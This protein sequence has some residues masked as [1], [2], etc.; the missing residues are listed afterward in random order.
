[1]KWK[2]KDIVKKI[3]WY[4]VFA[5]FPVKTEDGYKVWLEKVE[6][7]W[8]VHMTGGSYVYKLE[9]D[10][11]RFNISDMKVTKDDE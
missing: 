8:K 4:T 3:E 1:M 9:S 2:A 6:K 5:W 10:A 7:R 11:P